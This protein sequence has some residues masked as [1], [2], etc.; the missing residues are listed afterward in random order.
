LGALICSCLLDLSVLYLV[1]PPT[2]R[3]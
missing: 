1:G 2:R 3:V